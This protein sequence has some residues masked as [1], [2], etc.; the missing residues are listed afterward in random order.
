MRTWMILLG[1][2]FGSLIGYLANR[3]AIWMLFHPRKPVRLGPVV[4]Q[5]VFPRRKRDIARRVASIVSGRVITGE[6]IVEIVRSAVDRELRTSRVPLPLNSALISNFVREL[7]K[8]LVTL[9]TERFMLRAGSRIDLEDYIVKKFDE[10]SVEEFEV[11]FK[12][13]VGRELNYIALND[14]AIGALVGA[15]EMVIMGLVH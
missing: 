12:E 4:I 5:G 2:A 15:L 8:Y 9:L 11:M 10:V 6:E 7:A 13:A 3:L 1:S 14:A